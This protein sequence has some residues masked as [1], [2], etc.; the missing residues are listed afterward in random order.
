MKIALIILVPLI[1]IIGIVVLL[2]YLK[3]WNR[4]RKFCNEVD[5]ITQS[6]KQDDKSL[7]DLFKLINQQKFQD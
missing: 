5:K 3:K 7:D 1:I 2:S 4:N 6:E